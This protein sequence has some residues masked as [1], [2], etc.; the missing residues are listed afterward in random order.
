MLLEMLSWFEDKVNEKQD[1]FVV[2]IFG[3]F[4]VEDDKNE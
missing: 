4:L 2:K 1:V 3:V